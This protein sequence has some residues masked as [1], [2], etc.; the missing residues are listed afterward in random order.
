MSYRQFLA[1]QAIVMFLVAVCILMS[2]LV[3]FWLDNYKLGTTPMFTIV[4]AVVGSILATLGTLHVIVY[5]HNKE[6][7]KEGKSNG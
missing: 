2:A 1:K 3:G 7:G 6:D 4:G 5:G